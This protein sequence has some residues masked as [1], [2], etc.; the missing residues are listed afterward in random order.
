MGFP[1]SLGECNPNTIPIPPYELQSTFVKGGCI[2][3]D[4]GEYNRAD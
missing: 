2:G 1:A 3:D 4:I